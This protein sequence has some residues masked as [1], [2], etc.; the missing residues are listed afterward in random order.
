M[1]DLDLNYA[2]LIALIV[3]PKLN[4]ESALNKMG[5]KIKPNFNI[6]TRVSTQKI[7]D[8][9]ADK[10]RYLYKVEGLKIKEI[11]KLYD[12]SDMAVGNFMRKHH[13]E[14]VSRKRYNKKV[15]QNE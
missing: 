15:V 10:V 4:Y 1:S 7:K 9:D 14:T 6:G 8:S 13:I 2:A 12:V 5:I 11:A 3:N